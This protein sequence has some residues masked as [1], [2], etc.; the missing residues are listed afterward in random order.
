[1]VTSQTSIYRIIAAKAGKYNS[2]FRKSM[3]SR[4]RYTFSDKY[5]ANVRGSIFDRITG[6][7]E[8]ISVHSWLILAFIGKRIRRNSKFLLSSQPGSRGGSRTLHR[9]PYGAA[10]L[11][12]PEPKNK[13]LYD[14]SSGLLMLKSTKL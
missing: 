3:G 4:I 2:L 1:M 13:R 5:Y 11:F 8:L 6:Q 10:G 12:L 9:T 14:R 7:N